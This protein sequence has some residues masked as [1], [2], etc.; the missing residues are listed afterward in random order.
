MLNIGA[1]NVPVCHGF[2]RRSFLRAGSAGLAGLSLPALVNL[3]S[4]RAIDDSRAKIKNCIT[5]FLV[6]SPGHLDTWDM[7]PEAPAE[8]RGKFSPIETNVPGIQ[9]CEVFPQLAKRMDR[10]ALIRSIVGSAGDH[11][12]FQCTS[13][14]PRRALSNEG[15]YPSIGSVVWKLQGQVDR[16]VP[17]FIGLS[18]P[19]SHMEWSESGSPGFLG[20]AYAPFRP[21]AVANKQDDRPRRR[22]NRALITS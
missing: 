21:F 19:T 22:G 17:P 15:G 8:I 4:A 10:V 3:K 1:I 14:W 2:T 20:S 11:D 12:G 5:I 6:G 9:I 7:K 18:G 13:G 16:A